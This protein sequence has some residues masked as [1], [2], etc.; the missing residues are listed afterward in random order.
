M[1]EDLCRMRSIR[2]MFIVTAKIAMI[3]DAKQYEKK[4]EKKQPYRFN[5]LK[6]GIP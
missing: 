1:K 2:R 6:I 3:A 4:N 5:S